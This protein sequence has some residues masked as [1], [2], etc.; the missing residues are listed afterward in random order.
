M[1]L[2]F[3]FKEHL[4]ATV[5]GGRTPPIRRKSLRN[6]KLL[7]T[8]NNKDPRQPKTLGSEAQT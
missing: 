6:K 4:I 8:E 5:S 1:G 3:A 7:M 2:T